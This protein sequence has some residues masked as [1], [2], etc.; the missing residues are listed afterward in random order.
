MLIGVMVFSLLPIIL[1][2]IDVFIER[3]GMF[4]YRGMK[5]DFSLIPKRGGSEFTVPVNI[6]LPN[7]SVDNSSMPMHP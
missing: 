6:G 5:I 3:G 7:Q 4:E 1:T 2:F